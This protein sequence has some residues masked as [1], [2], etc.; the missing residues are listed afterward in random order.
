M[1]LRCQHQSPGRGEIERP[2]IACDLSQYEGQCAASYTLLHRPQDIGGTAC[3]DM[4]EAAAQCRRNTM[5]KWSPRKTDARRILDPQPLA[6]FVSVGAMFLCESK[7]QR[8]ARRIVAASE[9]LPHGMGEAQFWR[10]F[11]RIG[12]QRERQFRSIQGVKS[13]W[14]RS[15]VRQRDSMGIWHGGTTNRLD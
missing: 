3:L 10:P 2:W 15:T 7:C 6:I 1:P 13:A 4:D 14:Q 12:P 11:I 8:I 5:K 9:N